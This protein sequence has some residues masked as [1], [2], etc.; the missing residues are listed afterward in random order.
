M[1]FGNEIKTGNITENWLFEIFN[2]SSGLKFDGTDDYMDCGATTSSSPLALTSSTSMSLVMWIKFHSN[3]TG[4]QVLSV[5]MPTDDHYTGWW[6]RKDASTNAISINWGKDGGSGSGERETMTGNQALNADTWYAI[7][8]TTNFD[9]TST[10]NTSIYTMNEGGTPVV[11]SVTNSGTANINTPTYGTGNCYFG[12]YGSLVDTNFGNFTI[13]QCGV[14]TGA[15]NGTVMLAIANAGRDADYLSTFSGYS[16]ASSLVAY[17]DFRGGSS[18]VKDKKNTQ[19]GTVYGALK[20][21]AVNI[22]FSDFDKYRG[23]VLNKPSIRESIDLVNSTA[24]TSNISVS[25]VD[26]LFKGEKVSKAL[27]NGSL[28]YLNHFANVYSTVNGSLKRQIGSFRVSDI[29]RDKDKITLGLNSRKPWDYISFPQTKSTNG[30]YEPVV[31]GEYESNTTTNETKKNKVFPIPKIQGDGGKIYFAMHKA[32]TDGSVKLMAYD[33]TSDLFPFLTSNT[34]NQSLYGLNAIG[35]TDSLRRTFR[36]FPSSFVSSTNWSNGANAIANDGTDATIEN[37]TGTNTMIFNVLEFGGKV[38][39]FDI[40][41]D[42]VLSPDPS[43]GT[44]EDCQLIARITDGSSTSGNVV[45]LE[46]DVVDS[47]TST[48][49][50]PDIENSGSSYSKA[51]MS[52][53][54]SDENSPLQLIEVGMVRSSQIYDGTIDSIYFQAI[55]EA[56][57]TEPHS[58]SKERDDIKF[59]YCG[60]DGLTHQTTGTS[61]VISKT[62]EA[63]LDLLNRFTGF[64]VATN[65]STDIEGWSDLN[66]D[67][68]AWKLR[69]WQLDRSSLIDKLNLMQYEGGF[70]FRFKPDNTPQYIHIKNSYSSSDYTF[71]TKDISDI[72]VKVS[73]FSDIVTKA[74]INYEKHPAENRYL[75]SVTSSNTSRTTYNIEDKENIAEISLEAYVEPTIP[76]SP[77]TNPNDDFYTYYNNI[78]GT[79][80]LI[81]SGKIVNPK[82]YNVDVGDIVNFEDRPFDFF[83]TT[84]V[85]PSLR[86]DSAMDNYE[87]IE[88]LWSKGSDDDKY[89]MITSLKRTI[90]VLTF[91][92]REI[93]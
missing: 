43:D 46:T 16:N 87:D 66:T 22:S 72:N 5:N 23:V 60:N 83:N 63:H 29:S 77:S 38:I 76:S 31:Y 80:K 88:D 89:F 85:S 54:L 79:P 7:G 75:T 19:H 34:N 47:N 90:G 1:A 41:I 70:I 53:K 39:D 81:V 26:Y 27:Y 48:S 52:G 57:E 28:A 64:D 18:I 51:E 62:H 10:S 69:Y 68:S 56:P 8:I 33:S 21:D 59:V 71:T 50:N 45:A 32:I 12:R 44:E 40:F 86:W 73:S 3:N 15:L 37:K 24:Q 25:F 84:D 35:V 78:T 6:V 36:L 9:A 92:A 11:N 42:G 14:W 17:W 30:V 55:T 65:P 4:D 49:G 91:E 82:F 74:T 67:K 61:G 2:K 93:G 13:L 58:S 20:E